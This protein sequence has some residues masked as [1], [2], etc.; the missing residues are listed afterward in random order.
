MI[1]LN[2][3]IDFI[4]TKYTVDIT[5][6]TRKNQLHIYRYYYFYL[7]S[8]YLPFKSY[9]VIAKK[10]NRG[11]ASIT[12]GLNDLQFLQKTYRDINYELTNL[13]ADFKRG[14]K[15]YFKDLEEVFSY[16][17]LML[18]RLNYSLTNSNKNLNN[19]NSYYKRQNNKLKERIKILKK[20]V[21]I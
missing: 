21:D 16:D 12:I 8:K 6:P 4:N 20:L 3:I 17:L 19:N 15:D 5:L 9:S 14:F 1:E 10:V 13:E 11:H 2:D 7:A 18:Q